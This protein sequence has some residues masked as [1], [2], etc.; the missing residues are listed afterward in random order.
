MVVV[1]AV[2]VPAAMLV[3]AM[4]MAAVVVPA[5]VMTAVIVAA[6]VLT[7]RRGLQA[8]VIIGRFCREVVSNINRL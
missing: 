7:L 6:V 1:M 3:I 2:A 4:I 8:E 5:V